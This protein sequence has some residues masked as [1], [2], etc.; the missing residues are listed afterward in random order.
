MKRDPRL[1]DLDKSL[2]QF[3]YYTEKFKT[4]ELVH[5]QIPYDLAVIIHI[6][7][8]GG[9]VVDIFTGNL[10]GTRAIYR[11]AATKSAVWVTSFL[12]DKKMANDDILKDGLYE[13]VKKDFIEM[14]QHSD[15]KAK[16][17]NSY[18]NA[19]SLNGFM[20]QD[21]EDDDDYENSADVQY[22]YEDEE[23]TPKAQKE[24][25][26]MLDAADDIDSGKVKTLEKRNHD[27]K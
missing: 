5:Y 26:D 15:L 2:D 24:I 20:I 7:N 10:D 6:V 11:L 16:Y 27:E 13:T 4:D 12:Y 17:G 21:L 25:N 14:Q 8:I 23:I 22:G 1:Y 9:L 19:K 3:N 18:R